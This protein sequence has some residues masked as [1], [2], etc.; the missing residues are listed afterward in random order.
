MKKIIL[1]GMTASGKT[2][3]AQCLN[4][5][6]MEYQKTQALDV[7]NTTIDT[8]GEYLE[9]RSFLQSLIITSVDTDQVLFVQDAAQDRF[10]FSP[11]LASSF[12]VPVAGVVTK[13]D[14]AS[15][16]E[17]ARARELLELA[18]AEPIFETSAKSGEGID[19]L[20]LF[21]EQ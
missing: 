10:M 2:T 20:R 5:K 9:H 3:L 4:G 7:I 11:G 17:I 1:V 8:P 13:T 21:L 14:A 19:R 12:P 18:G 15:E 6:K 16:Q